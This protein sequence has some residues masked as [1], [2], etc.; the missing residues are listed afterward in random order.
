MEKILLTFL[1]LPLFINGYAQQETTLEIRFNDQLDQDIFVIVDEPPKF[2]GGEKKLVKFYKRKSKF[3]IVK[4]RKDGETVY[5]QIVINKNGSVTD[6]E[7]L[8]S[9]S[10][11]L[12]AEVRRMV[13]LMPLWNPGKLNG[14]PVRV[15][16]IQEISFSVND[17]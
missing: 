8:N 14:K 5:F 13:E 11:N 15:K 6:F 17:Q 12:A 9:I 3:D 7:I 10:K 4:D 16:V 2:K 1:L